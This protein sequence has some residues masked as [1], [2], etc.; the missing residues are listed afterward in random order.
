K[1]A[2]GVQVVDSTLMQELWK[3][4]TNHALQFASPY[5]ND[6]PYNN[7]YGA[8][9]IYY[10]VGTWLDIYNPTHQYQEQISADGAY[11]GIIWVNRCTNTVGV[12][13]TFIPSLF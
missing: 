3:D 4:Q 1:S 2:T 9:T 12:F 8:D 11:G 5:P 13:L 7:P 10:G 6:P